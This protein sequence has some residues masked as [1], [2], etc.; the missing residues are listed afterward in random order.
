[1]GQRI[2]WYLGLVLVATALIL[3]P[4]LSAGPLWTGSSLQ[5]RHEDRDRD[6]REHRYYDREHKDYHVWNDREERAYRH[7]L[8]ERRENYRD[9]AKEK[10]KEQQEYWKWR[11]K[12]PGETWERRR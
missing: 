11:H 7:W 2:S 6:N 9:F 4:V 5:E 1:M 3:P 12:Y 8:E 10:R